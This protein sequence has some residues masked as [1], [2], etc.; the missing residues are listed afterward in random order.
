M[1]S[2]MIDADEGVRAP[3]LGEQ[4]SALTPP[5]R[6]DQTRSPRAGL[7]RAI[8]PPR[9]KTDTR[10]RRR[11]KSASSCLAWRR[12]R[13]SLLYEASQRWSAIIYPR[14]QLHILRGR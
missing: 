13:W 4:P 12:G 6:G 8:P 7:D 5:R 10:T 14:G 1:G 11:V 3:L 9:R 2:A